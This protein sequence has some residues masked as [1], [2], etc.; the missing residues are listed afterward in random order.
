MWLVIYMMTVEIIWDLLG[1]STCEKVCHSCLG[2]NSHMRIRPPWGE[3]VYFIWKLSITATTLYT[4]GD[5]CTDII[6]QSTKNTIKNLLCVSLFN[7]GLCQF[8]SASECELF[9][10]E[11]G[12]FLSQRCERFFVFSTCDAYIPSSYPVVPRVHIPSAVGSTT[13]SSNQ[14]LLTR[15]LASRLT[16]CCSWLLWKCWCDTD[17]KVYFVIIWDELIIH[18]GHSWSTFRT[19]IAYWH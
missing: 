6:V 8:I 2:L 7:S 11:H 3:P 17:C 14:H 18:W 12:F 4:I 10:S 15:T 9:F 1:Y 13:C 5:W 16:R 19:K